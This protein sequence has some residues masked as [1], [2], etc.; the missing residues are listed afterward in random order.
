[1]DHEEV[2]CE[3]VDWIYFAQDMDNFVSQTRQWMEQ[4]MIDQLS[5]SQLLKEDYASWN[6]L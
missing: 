1:M 5:S 6:Y 2:G 4:I 3:S